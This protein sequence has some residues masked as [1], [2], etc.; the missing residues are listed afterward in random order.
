MQ[1]FRKIE[2]ALR[3]DSVIRKTTNA[4]FLIPKLYPDMAHRVPVI[5]H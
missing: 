2:Y 1:S 3:V 4:R 5:A